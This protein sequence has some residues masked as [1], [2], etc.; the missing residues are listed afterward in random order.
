M[1]TKEQIKEAIL[2]TTGYPIIGAIVENVD[3]LV[4][5]I[6][7]LDNPAKTKEVRILEASETR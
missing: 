1:A 7:L 3:A 5:A 6:Y 2:S 4:D